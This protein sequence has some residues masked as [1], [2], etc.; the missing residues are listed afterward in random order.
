MFGATQR[1][2]RQARQDGYLA[3]DLDLRHMLIPPSADA[4]RTSLDSQVVRVRSVWLPATLSGPLSAQRGDRLAGFLRLAQRELGLRHMIIEGASQATRA[5]VPLLPLAR[6][7]ARE[8]S[9]MV[10]LGLGVRAD[11]SMHSLDS[12]ALAR[13]VAEEWELDLALDVAGPVPPGWEAEAAVVRLMPRLA[14]VRL[15]GWLPLQYAHED[16]SPTRIAART[17]SML[18]DQGYAGLLSIV[19]TRNRRPSTDYQHDLQRRYDAGPHSADAPART[20][21]DLP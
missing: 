9:G 15:C 7:V 20:H 2:V 16:G 13:R 6:E 12:T 3:L 5:G 1:P 4:I 19:P 8:Q 14:V 21:F 17:M 11:R 10:R 18:A